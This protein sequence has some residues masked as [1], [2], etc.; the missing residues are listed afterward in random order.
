LGNLKAKSNNG[1][2]PLISFIC[3]LTLDHEAKS[4]TVALLG[5]SRLGA[6]G[7][8]VIR[9]KARA[10]FWWCSIARRHSLGSYYL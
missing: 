9:E 8:S 3:S 2:A 4:H 10:K 1:F 5:Q 7:S 6:K